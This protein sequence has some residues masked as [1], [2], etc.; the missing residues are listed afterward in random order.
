MLFAMLSTLAFLPQR[1]SARKDGLALAA[2]E[3]EDDGDDQSSS[4]KIIIFGGAISLTG[5]TAVIVMLLMVCNLWL[6]YAVIKL[7]R[8]QKVAQY[9]VAKMADSDLELS[10]LDE[11]VAINR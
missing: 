5:F 1:T 10:A 9:A 4:I 3:R 8:E 7:R 2:D 11:V 6:C